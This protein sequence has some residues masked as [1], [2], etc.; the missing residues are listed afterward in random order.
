MSQTT[1]KGP[2]YATGS[3]PEGCVYAK[4]GEL[5]VPWS[6]LLSERK[7]ANARLIAQAPAMLALLRETLHALEHMTSEEFACGVDKPIRDKITALLKKI[8]G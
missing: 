8:G 6:P 3:S 4:D 1:T 5:I 7:M 2:W